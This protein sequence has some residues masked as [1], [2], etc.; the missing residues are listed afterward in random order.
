MKIILPFLALLFVSTVGFAQ[1]KL[2]SHKS[3]SGSSQNFSKAYKNNLFNLRQSNFGHP[4]NMN[5]LVVDTIIALN[6]F[7]TLVKYRE[8]NICHRFGTDYKTLTEDDFIHKTDTLKND[9]IFFKQNSE[10]KIK[11][12]NSSFV[13]NSWYSNPIEQVV[14]IG[15]KE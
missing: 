15:F 6:E 7:V 9:H 5:I 14:F 1:T 4:G 8:S 13:G 2:I 11:A 3:H 10:K 12:S